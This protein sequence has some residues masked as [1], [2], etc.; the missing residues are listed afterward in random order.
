MYDPTFT[1]IDLL[2]VRPRVCTA[3][4]VNRFNI[5]QDGDSAAVAGQPVRLFGQWPN[6]EKPVIL[7]ATYG[8]KDKTVDVTAKLKAYQKKAPLSSLSKYNTV[9]GDPV[10]GEVKQLIIKYSGNGQTST[11]TFPENSSIQLLF[12]TRKAPV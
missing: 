5:R 8:T 11:V 9:F 4:D 1:H 6:G 2:P 10:G 3:P 12:P 7:K